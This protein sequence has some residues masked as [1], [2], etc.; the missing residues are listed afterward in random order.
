MRSAVIG[1]SS[2]ER[3]VPNTCS[4]ISTNLYL[5]PWIQN[6]QLFDE[7]TSLSVK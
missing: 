1:V 7:L 5:F 4:W 2:V 3:L 6:T